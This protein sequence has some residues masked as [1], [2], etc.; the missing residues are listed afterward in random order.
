MRASDHLLAGLTVATLFAFL[1]GLEPEGL[2]FRLAL[3]LFFVAGSVAPDK[4]WGHELAYGRRKTY[5]RRR[6]FQHSLAFAFL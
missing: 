5:L 1:P 3:G 4:L 2:A 6:A